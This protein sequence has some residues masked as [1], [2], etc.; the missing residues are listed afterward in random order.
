MTGLGA[1]SLI[2]FILIVPP[3]TVQCFTASFTKVTAPMNAP[4]AKSQAHALEANGP[5]VRYAG[6]Q[7]PA[8]NSLAL[9]SIGYF[10]T[11]FCIAPT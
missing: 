9:R 8:T 7:P 4:A 11:R 10:G 1:P 2:S 5:Q 6:R 3:C